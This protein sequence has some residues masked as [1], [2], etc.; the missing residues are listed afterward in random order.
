MIV[1]LR[2]TMT[3]RHVSVRGVV[4]TPRIPAYR[5]QVNL[6]DSLPALWKCLLQVESWTFFLWPNP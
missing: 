5:V 3:A 6:Y 2:T 1:Y 4:K